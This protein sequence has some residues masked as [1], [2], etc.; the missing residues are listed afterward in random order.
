MT[1]SASSG[2]AATFTAEPTASA[3]GTVALEEIQSASVFFDLSLQALLSF[4][5]ICGSSIDAS[6][7]RSTDQEFWILKPFEAQRY[8]W[9]VFLYWWIHGRTV[10]GISMKQACKYF[11]SKSATRQTSRLP[12][13]SNPKLCYK[14]HLQELCN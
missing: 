5:G 12:A 14:F 10:M 6:K 8:G 9:S 4:L 3:S 1:T 7:H 2:R 13:E 11:S